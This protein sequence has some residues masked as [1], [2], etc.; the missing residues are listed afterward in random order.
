MLLKPTRAR[1][2][3]DVVERSVLDAVRDAHV[4]HERK[5]S[6]N[7]Q[8]TTTIASSKFTLITFHNAISTMA[9]H[10]AIST[11]FATPFNCF[12]LPTL[13]NNWT[14]GAACRHTTAPLLSF[15][16][17]TPHYAKS[18]HENFYDG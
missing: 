13:V 12:P 5:H 2:Q 16:G 14:R 18:I 1:S 6:S 7:Q 9:P 10:H 17:I 15:P 11:T 4:H 8:T 3:Y